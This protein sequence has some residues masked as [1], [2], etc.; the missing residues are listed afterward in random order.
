[1]KKELFLAEHV[2]DVRGSKIVATAWMDAKPV[3]V[4]STGI[5]NSCDSVNRR[6]KDGTL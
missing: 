4:V 1:M 5:A 3:D 2:M 6:F